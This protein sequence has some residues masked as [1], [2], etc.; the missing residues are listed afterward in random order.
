MKCISREA[1][2]CCTTGTRWLP[3][4]RRF[5][6]EIGILVENGRRTNAVARAK[7]EYYTL[8]KSDL[9]QFSIVS[10]VPRLSIGCLNVTNRWQ[11][12]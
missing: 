9:D 1:C 7:C 10:G 3:L 4:M 12:S 5:F 8:Q 6:G 2:V 11:R